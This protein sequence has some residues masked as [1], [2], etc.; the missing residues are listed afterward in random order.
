ME[1]RM[2]FDLD[3]AR[4]D[5]YRPGYAAELYREIFRYFG[6]R[7]GMKALEVGIGTGLATPPILETGCEVVAVEAGP[8]L[9]AYVLEKF[10]WAANFRVV[11][12][13]FERY[14][15]GERFDL[16][17]S[18]TAFHWIEEEVGYLKVLR[19]LKP[20]GA[21]ALFWNRPFANHPG[22]PLHVDIRKIY[23]KYRPDQAEPEPFSER[24]CQKVLDALGRYG[25]I[26]AECR[27]FYRTRTLSAADY[28]GLLR[29]Y[30]DHQAAGEDERRGLIPEIEAAIAAHGGEITLH[31]T[32][33]LYL[34]RRGS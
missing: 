3:P 24:N 11:C 8:N 13:D 18:A 10:S 20:G 1:R 30:S 28:A 19:L 2:T 17:Y 33:D 27:L 4:Y 34:A 21:V 15:P 32:M 14:E 6:L 12:S 5:R 25:F 26:D 22:D 29:T 9:A 31:D 16:I 7:R 23:R